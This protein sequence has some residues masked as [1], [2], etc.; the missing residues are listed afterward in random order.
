MSQIVS[1]TFVQEENYIDGIVDEYFKLR[2]K[3]GIHIKILAVNLAVCSDKK[4]VKSFMLELEDYEELER[5]A[6]GV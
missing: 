6:A 1:R 2:E 4:I 5:R 3:Q